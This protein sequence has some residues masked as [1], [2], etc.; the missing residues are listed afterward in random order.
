MATLHIEHPISD[1]GIWR[2]AFDR[3]AEMRQR[4]GV[5]AQRIQQPVD[6]PHYVVIDL[7][8][9]S[10]AEAEALLAFLYAEV[11]SSR[12]AAPALA[13]APQTRILQPA[14]VGAGGVSGTG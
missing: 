1:F 3:F 2:A 10:V 5:R 7:D 4:A 13:G 12:D 8:F 14:Q 6:D 11:W 9:D